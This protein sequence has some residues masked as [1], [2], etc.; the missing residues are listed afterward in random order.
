MFSGNELL[1]SNPV[2]P[3]DVI[4][5]G[6]VR[7]FAFVDAAITSVRQCNDLPG[8]AAGSTGCKMVTLAM[9]LRGL[10]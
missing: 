6:N 8:F 2:V 10:P 7:F 3:F 5:D 1:S 9:D 4:D